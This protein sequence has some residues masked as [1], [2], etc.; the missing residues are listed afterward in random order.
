MQF[1]EICLSG[2]AGF[3]NI[4]PTPQPCRGPGRSCGS[5]SPRSP[6][7]KVVGNA[8][9]FQVLTKSGR[10]NLGPSHGFLVPT[11]ADSDWPFSS[12]IHFLIEITREEVLTPTSTNFWGFFF[13]HRIK[14]LVFFFNNDPIQ[15]K[16]VKIKIK[17][18][19]LQS[20]PAW[21][22]SPFIMTLKW[23]MAVSSQGGLLFQELVADG[24]LIITH[25]SPSLK[26]RNV[27]VTNFFGRR[28]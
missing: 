6:V 15:P 10:G 19:L 13:P 23:K 21:N 27:K 2:W 5:G 8:L 22:L 12:V 20:G 14:I 3:C 17:G 26:K 25:W 28:N 1:P 18:G 11:A 7:L 9:P 16:R 4:T 24:D